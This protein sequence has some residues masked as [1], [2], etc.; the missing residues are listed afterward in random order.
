[1]SESGYF[2]TPLMKKLGARPGMRALFVDYSGGIA[3]I[4]AFDDWSERVDVEGSSLPE[5]RFDYIHV[6]IKLAADLEA[7]AGDLKSRLVAAG[8]VW[9]SWPKKASGVE[10]TLDGNAVRRM[11]LDAGLV[12]IKVCA[13]DAV[14]S[15]LKFVI[16]V[17]DR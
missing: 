2:G 6:F 1:M 3:A 10:T 17:K 13:V 11:G 15:G 5:G 12:D 16:P 7:I 8:M 9:I 4:D 14:W